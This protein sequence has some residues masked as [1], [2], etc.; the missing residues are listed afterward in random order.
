MFP[1]F[2]QRQTVNHLKLARWQNFGKSVELIRI[3]LAMLFV[4]FCSSR[5]QMLD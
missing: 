2:Y 3:E 1:V 4:Q 5:I